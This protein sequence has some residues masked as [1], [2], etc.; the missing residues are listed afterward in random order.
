MYY[1]EQINWNANTNDP[2]SDNL[3]FAWTSD[4]VGITFLDPNGLEDATIEDPNIALTTVDP[5]GA[6][7]YTLK[8]TVTDDSSGGTGPLSTEITRDLTIVGN[9]D[10]TADAGDATANVTL[11]GPDLGILGLEGV[12]PADDGYPL[13]PGVLTI[14]WEADD[15]LVIIADPAS[16]VTTADFNA[17]GAGTYTLTLTADDGGG[18]PAVDTIVVTVS[19]FAMASVTITPTDDT[20]V[21]K[22][23]V[24]WNQGPDNTLRVVSIDHNATSYTYV[25][26]DIGANVPGAIQTAVLNMKTQE[27]F[28][29]TRVSAVTYGPTGEW[30]EGD[31]SDEGNGRDGGP[32]GGI[33]WATDDLV[34]GSELDFVEQAAAETWYAFDV[35]S[36]R[37]EDDGKATFGLKAD[38]ETATN[39]DWW[40]KDRGAAWAPNLVI[41]YQSSAAH[42]LLPVNGAT[43]VHPDADLSWA[44]GAGAV[45]EQLI[46]WDAAD[47][48]LLNVIVDAN[49]TTGVDYVLDELAVGETVY[50]WQVISRDASDITIGETAVNSFTTLLLHPDYPINI[51]PADA[52]ELVALPVMF[53]FVKGDD[54]A[55]TGTHDVVA[56]PAVGSVTTITD[57]IP[58]DPNFAADLSVDTEYSWVVNANGSKG[59]FAGDATSFTT[60]VC[61]I[62][63]DFED[64][65]VLLA[66]GNAIVTEELDIVLGTRSMMVDYTD[67][68]GDTSTATLALGGKDLS[69][70]RNIAS[71]EI[72]FHGAFDNS[73]ESLW[74]SIDDGSDAVIVDYQ[75]EAADLVQET[76]DDFD[77]FYIDL[78]DP[79]FATLNLASVQN[80]V[81]GLGD[82][83][84][85]GNSGILYIDN[86]VACASRC[87]S[88]MVAGNISHNEATECSVNI[89]DLMVVV[90]SWLDSSETVDAVSATTDGLIVQFDFD[91]VTGPNAISS[92]SYDGS[93]VA[94]GEGQG[95]PTFGV[96]GQ[97]GNAIDM[98]GIGYVTIKDPATVLASVGSEMTISLWC[99]GNAVPGANGRVP[100]TGTFRVDTVTNNL[101]MYSRAPNGVGAPAFGANNMGGDFMSWNDSVESDWN[102][103]WNHYAYVIDAA[104]DLQAL[105]VNG[106]MVA[107]NNED[108]TGFVFDVAG[109]EAF[110]IGKQGTYHG[111]IDDFR[112]Y[113]RALPQGEIIDL[114]GL[115]SVTQPVVTD[116]S[117][118]DIIEDGIINLLDFAVIAESWMLTNVLWP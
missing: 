89:D 109:L 68:G 59:T 4:P 76:W 48:E 7:V 52:A 26:F 44:S 46:M 36:L 100:N 79:A 56:T 34:W 101:A 99:N 84:E 45:T 116:E 2:D 96:A 47:V 53:D 60:A 35:T 110:E 80:I 39:H 43:G 108:V 107:R 73:P 6:G 69:A 117:D 74:V 93:N 30:F 38:A 31:G 54:A 8:L 1:D 118:P 24:G 77:K 106:V 28:V 63:A 42:S 70:A 57:T 49:E 19:Q 16:A 58:D 114:A 115:G 9:V 102:G 113:N 90:R 21:W 37:L 11:A 105:Y 23:R 81:I 25:K 71:L 13:V 14:T 32:S 10:P 72:N 5:A 61:D 104:A 41:T 88:E 29:E 55:L 20:C 66:G 3:T 51:S 82:G 111:K 22:N 78:T 87:I 33:T 112:I 12:V 98:A 62:I 91:E 95:T 18:N 15:A 85:A 67:A 17:A 97:I 64:G 65:T 27:S 83:A 92:V 86:I 75:G 103:V 94:I 50:K 40:A